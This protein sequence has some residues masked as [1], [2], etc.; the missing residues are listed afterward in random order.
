MIFSHRYILAVIAVTSRHIME[1]IDLLLRLVPPDNIVSFTTQNLQFLVMIDSFILIYFCIKIIIFIWF[2]SKSVHTF[3]VKILFFSHLESFQSI[4]LPFDW[5]MIPVFRCNKVLYHVVSLKVIKVGDFVEIDQFRLSF[6]LV[7]RIKGIR[8]VACLDILLYTR[9]FLFF[10][11]KFLWMNF[12]FIEILIQLF[13]EIFVT[14]HDFLT[15]FLIIKLIVSLYVLIYILIEKFLLQWTLCL[16]LMISFH[17]KHV[18]SIVL[19]LIM[20]LM[21]K[22]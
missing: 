7:D 22:Y 16:I 8:E 10:V 13:L 9:D 6:L 15:C 21:D 5:V 11:Y 2:Y 1:L 19:V 17:I 18:H 20:F 3:F 12:C 4:I 14:F